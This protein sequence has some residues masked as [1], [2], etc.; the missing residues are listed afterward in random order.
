MLCH[1]V[2]CLQYE[3]DTIFVKLARSIHIVMVSCGCF[4]DCAYMH[5]VEWNWRKSKR[6]WQSRNLDPA[7]RRLFRIFRHLTVNKPGCLIR[8]PVPCTNAARTFP[9][10]VFGANHY[11]QLLSDFVICIRTN[12]RP[13]PVLA[14]TDV[15]VFWQRSTLKSRCDIYEFREVAD[16]LSPGSGDHRNSKCRNI[17]AA[18]GEWPSSLWSAP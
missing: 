9:L 18:A 15:A 12:R 14:M 17:S 6:S 1:A 7:S 3:N 10:C 5:L 8:V 16:S 13:T 4:Q 2:N 11:Y